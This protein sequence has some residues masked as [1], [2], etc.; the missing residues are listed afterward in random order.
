MTNR[1]FA[2]VET[3]FVMPSQ[4]YAYLSARLIKEIA[5]LGGDVSHL[6]PPDVAAVLADRLRK[7][8]GASPEPM[9][10]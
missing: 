6:V 3:L 10:D 8:P 5:A 4:E 9:R 7:R 1:S 2:D